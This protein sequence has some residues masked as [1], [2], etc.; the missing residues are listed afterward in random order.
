MK[1]DAHPPPGQSV[2]PKAGPLVESLL[3]IPGALV[4]G[5]PR[6]IGTGV[7]VRTLENGARVLVQPTAPADASA[8]GPVAI[9]LWVLA[10]TAAESQH[11]HGCAHL[12]E[13]MLFKP[14]ELGDGLRDIASAIESL[15][16]DVN[17]Y[18]S[19]D[20]TVFHATAP[21]AVFEPVMDALVRPVVTPKLD[22]D[23][24]QREIGVVVEEIKQY[25][26][27]PAARA[28]QELLAMLYRDHGYG[29]PVLGLR[30]EVS[31]HDRRRLAGFHRAVYTADRVVL[32]VV[33]PVSPR[34]VLT[35]ARR[36]L[37]DLPPRGRVLTTREPG[38]LSAPRVRAR[39]CDSAEAHIAV[40]WLAPP[41]PHAE[42]CALEVASVILGY[43]EASRLS[44]ET[45]RQ[46][47]VVTDAQAHFYAARHGSSM[48]VSVATTRARA[49]VAATAVFDQ[50]DRLRSL[51][52][53][54]DELD[55][56][57]AVL[58]SDVVY[59]RETVQGLAH[60]LGY[61]LSLGGDLEG[62]QRYFEA[63]S[64]LG[65]EAV[66][67]AC[68]EYLA[69]ERTAVNVLLP[70]RGR[71]PVPR[72][73][74][75]VVK[76]RLR[77]YG[78][79]GARPRVALAQGI[80]RVD[81]PGGLR[82]RAMIDRSI[83]MA[84]GWLVWPGGLR[85][86]TPRDLGVSSLMAALLTRGT[87][88]TSGDALAREIESH[89]AVLEGFSGRNSLGL[90]F[91]CLAPNV[92]MLLRRA[93][94]CALDPRFE[95]S[96]LEEER[97]VA[98]ED[99][100]AERDD[101]AGLAFH[102]AHEL[103]YGG[104]PFGRRRHGTRE[105]LTRLHPRRLASL[106]SRGYPIGRA[107]LGL[108][109]DLDLEEIAGLFHALV[110]A[111]PPPPPLQWSQPGAP[112]FP[113]RPRRRH[114]RLAKEQAHFVIAFPGLPMGDPRLPVLEVLTT[115]L[116][117]QAGRLFDV[118]REQE[119]L[120]YN[121]SV[122]STE[123]ID[124]GHVAVYA[125]TSQ[126]TLE[127]AI[128]RSWGELDRV[129]ASRPAEDEVERAK[130]WLVGQFAVEMQRRSRV[131]AQIAFDEA[132]GLGVGAHLRYAQRVERV[133]AIDVWRLARLIFDRRRSV[134]AIVSA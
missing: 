14:A 65:P 18:T 46:A 54:Q 5:M 2:G 45:R 23:E 112:R 132:Y 89:A 119:G 78:R 95:G 51:P 53:E 82:V 114:I 92:P 56:A 50:I 88:S 8:S 76:R 55:R 62:E 31:Q 118:L 4:D 25:D 85:A 97:R 110:P 19:H 17:A 80:H 67:R 69:P 1:P 108:C 72:E 35:R 70:R 21:A 16:G 68:A 125:A 99:L 34:R 124:A 84:A 94:D 79:E 102:S 128:A 11:E 127:R 71:G 129:C 126:D 91:E 81:L 90:H 116:G 86:E 131:A 61:Q 101:P 117:G 87:H 27:D 96:E 113:S 40:A 130:A 59:R 10:G 121:V 33:G 39:S 22:A 58:R 109:G 104:H 60:A 30:R 106:W 122:S 28:S 63:L 7:V 100:E 57:R 66:R 43:G 133:R 111:D 107:T 15:G 20:E 49:G 13:H 48:L 38:P 120:V 42:A 74:T 103:L 24:L 41:L 6:S 73:I 83:P 77:G 105:S 93:F 123:G 29:R 115:I 47:R 36:L 12:L 52:V 98:L 64:R 32:V 9:E 134:E 37:R 44:I 75:A 26:D 3:G